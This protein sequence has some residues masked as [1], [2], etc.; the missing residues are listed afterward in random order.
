M[1]QRPFSTIFIVASI[2][3]LL[4]LSYTLSSAAPMPPSPVVNHQTHQCAVIVPGDECGDV[5]LPSGWE[6]L[7]EAAGE[8]CPEGYATIELHP[9]WA[10]FKVPHCCMEGHS[11]V[12][13]DCQDVVI[14]Q[15]NRRCAFVEDIQNC[16]G[17]PDSWEAWGEN[18]PTK[19][20]WVDDVTCTGDQTGSTVFPTPPSNFEPTSTIMETDTSGGGGLVGTLEPTVTISK[21]SNAMPCPSIAMILVGLVGAGFWHK[22]KKLIPANLVSGSERSGLAHTST[23]STDLITKPNKKLNV[24]TPMLKPAI[25]RKRLRNGWSFATEI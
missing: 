12:S 25:S 8:V 21:P 11:G 24:A 9:E 3:L 4:L 20:E 1:D 10:H 17:L 23:P 13:G 2:L 19:F 5:I 18:C 22:V 14:D 16:Q 6:Y 15:S 7:D